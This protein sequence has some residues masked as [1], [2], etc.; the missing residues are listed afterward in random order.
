[1]AEAKRGT[2]F[3]EKAAV[4]AFGIVCLVVFICIRFPYGNFRGYLEQAIGEKIGRPVALGPIHPHFPLGIRVSGVSVEGTERVK[5]LILRPHVLSPLTGKVGMDVKALLPAGSLTCSFDRPMGSLRT[6]MKARVRME[7]FDSS[8]IHVFFSTKMEPRGAIT[9]SI[10]LAGP[11]PS[12]EALGGSASI[13]WKDGFIPLSGSQLPFDGLTFATMV[14][15]SRI[16]RGMVTLDKMELKGDMSGVVRGSV[17][18]MD[19]AGRSR[20]NLAGELTLAQALS[21]AMAAAPR[22]ALKFSLRGTLD[23]PRFRILGSP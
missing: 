16:E 1:M 22:G 17:W 5:D 4:A 19:P 7:N 21:S 13:V 23:R 20:L 10:D 6:S 9:G 14:M 12:L 18:M 3:L 15:D 2:P 8:L 11:S